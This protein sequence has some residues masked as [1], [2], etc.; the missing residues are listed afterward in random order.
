MEEKI[1]YLTKTQTER[2]LIVI[3]R[4]GNKRDIALF[5]VSYIL[6]LRAS[7]V[8]QL[9]IEDFDAN[10]SQ[11]YVRRLKGSVSGSMR[12]DDKRKRH[13]LR[14]LRSRDDTQNPKAPLFL[15]RQQNKGVGRSLIHHLMMKY[16]K[17][18]NLPID[19][20]HFHVLRH[21]IGVHLAEAGFDVKDLQ[22]CLG[23]KDLR[24][25]QIYFSYT[26]KQQEDFYL[27]MNERSHSFA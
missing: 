16:S 22:W 10:S 14:Y 25:T 3:E 18:A 19:R 2:L 5:H 11:I 1:K 26:T 9:K 23:H 15:S 24:N 20:R 7:E 21:S 12:L 27:K 6:G 13:L 8:G 17:K 4:H